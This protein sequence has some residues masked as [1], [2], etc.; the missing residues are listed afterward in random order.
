VLFRL[1]PDIESPILELPDLTDVETVKMFRQWEGDPTYLDLLRFIRISS[2]NPFSIS[3]VR[4]S[5]REAQLASATAKASKTDNSMDVVE[6]HP[7]NP[8]QTGFPDIPG[9]N[10]SSTMQ[11][12]DAVMS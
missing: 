9:N 5:R 6:S 8:L 11:T 10:F 4:L 12:M 1:S 2:S 3:L 7:N